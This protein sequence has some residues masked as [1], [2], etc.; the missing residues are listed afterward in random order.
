MDKFVQISTK[1]NIETP[2]KWIQELL[3]KWCTYKKIL[4]EILNIEIKE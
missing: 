3:P 1:G 4:K 2:K